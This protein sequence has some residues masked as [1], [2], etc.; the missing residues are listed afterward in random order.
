MKYFKWSYI[1]HFWLRLAVIAQHPLSRL[2]LSLILQILLQ[3]KRWRR[4]YFYFITWSLSSDC[5]ET[6]GNC[7][8]DCPVPSL[9]YWCLESPWT[10]FEFVAV[11]L[12]GTNE[13]TLSQIQLVFVSFVNN[14]VYNSKRGFTFGNIWVMQ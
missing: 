12:N 11:R 3:S 7:T 13:S 8:P 9:F 4:L 2:L 6:T 1:W 14:A 5:P 10:I